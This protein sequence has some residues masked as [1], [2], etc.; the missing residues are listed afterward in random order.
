MT[1]TSATF[2]YTSSAA[3]V[4]ISMAWQWGSRVSGAIEVE[5]QLYR[6]TPKLSTLYTECSAH[7]IEHSPNAGCL[8][9][10]S[11]VRRVQV[12][13]SH[14]EIIDIPCFPHPAHLE[15]TDILCF[16]QSNKVSHPLSV[17]LWSD[18]S[19]LL[20]FCFLLTWNTRYSIAFCKAHPA[21]KLL[22]CTVCCYI[23]CDHT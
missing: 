1:R 6:V 19:L 10:L 23:S 18:Y 11:M 7:F 8:F 15:P 20:S 9:S 13:A 14:L 5:G 12:K 22:I 3:T 21:D 16:P 2:Y 4:G 17:H